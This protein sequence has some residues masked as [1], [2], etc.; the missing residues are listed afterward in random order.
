MTLRFVR[1][2]LGYLS[3]IGLLFMASCESDKNEEIVN[4]SMSTEE[5][6]NVIEADDISSSIDNLLE[7]DYDLFTAGKTSSNRANR[8]PGCVER[9]V[10]E[11][12]NGK[13]VILDYGEGCGRFVVLA[14]VIIKEY[15]REE[16]SYSRKV[17]F[18]NFSINGNVFE[19][20]KSFSKVRENA[21]GNPQ[22]TIV[23]DLTITLESGEVVMNKGE[24]VKEV[25][26][27]GDTRTRRDD[28]VS[29]SGY[30]EHT[31]DGE[32]RSV[33]IT[34]N[35]IRN[36]ACRYIE[37]GVVEVT[38]RNGDMYSVDF[39]DGTCDNKAVVTKPDG[40]TEEITLRRPFKF[41]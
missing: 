25:I 33:E 13:R 4:D 39:G 21:N 27:G 22:V 18:E 20:E 30:W 3:V 7:E 16:G 32:T 28:V 23:S 26:E 36:H 41:K 12:P 37:S 34:D 38:R 29:I 2:N 5:V 35:L 14:G 17:T 11:I 31:K 8:P 10:E 15:T 19:G 24:K 1:R 9:T 40:T 6:L